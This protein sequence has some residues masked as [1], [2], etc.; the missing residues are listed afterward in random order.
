[1][2]EALPAL[3]AWLSQ[4]QGTDYMTS[5]IYTHLMDEFDDENVAKSYALRLIV[6]YMGDIMQPLH[7]ETHYDSEFPEGD[8]GGNDVPLK[9][10]YDVDELHALWDKLMYDGYHNVDRPFTNE[11]W[12]AWQVNVT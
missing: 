4:K 10:H 12:T 9:Y 5:S 8:K 3:V 7:C 6:H 2:T 11:T 1:M